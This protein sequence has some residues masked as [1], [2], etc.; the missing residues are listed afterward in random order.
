MHPRLLLVAPIAALALGVPIDSRG[1]G[2]TVKIATVEGASAALVA[3]TPREVTIDKHVPWKKSGGTDDAPQ[4]ELGAT[5]PKTMTLELGFDSPDGHASVVDRYWPAIDAFTVAAPP[6]NRPP[7]VSVTL[8]R[9][10]AFKGVVTRA[11]SKVTR[12]ADDGTPLHMDVT[13]TV[14]RAESAVKR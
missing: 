1:A 14:A 9:A 11:T 6:L 13:L 8:G 4:M 2:A 5:D 7:L 10:G 12:F 3:P